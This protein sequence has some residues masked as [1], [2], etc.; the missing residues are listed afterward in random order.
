MLLKEDLHHFFRISV[1]F[2]IFNKR[3]RLICECIDPVFSEEIE[4]K[5]EIELNARK[6]RE[7]VVA[8][9]KVLLKRRVLI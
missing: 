6:L 3:K 1:I 7:K 2:P 8:I 9:W 5:L 4:E